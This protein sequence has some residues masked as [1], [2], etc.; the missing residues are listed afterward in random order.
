MAFLLYWTFE[1][2]NRIG[3]PTYKRNIYIY[4][5]ICE[6][7]HGSWT[8]LTFKENYV[9]R[10]C[11]LHV[12][13]W[14]NP[15][16]HL[17]F[18]ML[19]LCMLVK[20]RIS[21]CTFPWRKELQV[22]LFYLTSITLTKVVKS[23]PP[24][25]PSI[26]LSQNDFQNS[27]NSLGFRLNSDE[28]LKLDLCCRRSFVFWILTTMGRSHARRKTPWIRKKKSGTFKK[29]PNCHEFRSVFSIFFTWC[30]FL[31]G[32]EQKHMGC[33]FWNKKVKEDRLGSEERVGSLWE[34]PWVWCESC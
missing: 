30:F 27:L 19:R 6:S 20:S 18:F 26:S 13:M 11:M 4:I 32:C 17:N 7:H 21:F 1:P 34:N 10:P 5:Y 9:R 22:P 28:V 14:C 15:E 24:F 8:C 16:I 31:E 25:L 29:V 23:L 2:L 12:A 33:F 3:M